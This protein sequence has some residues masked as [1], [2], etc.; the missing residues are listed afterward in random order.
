[1]TKRPSPHPVRYWR[2]MNGEKLLETATK[3]GISESYLSL[4]ERKKR[5][6]SPQLAIKIE[7]K[8]G[9]PRAELR[10]DLWADL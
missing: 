7:K 4:L 3:L 10:P 2:F 8:L 5:G 6:I 1:M 9:I